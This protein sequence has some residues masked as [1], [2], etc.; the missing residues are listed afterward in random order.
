VWS[1]Y[2]GNLD[3]DNS[4]STGINN[5]GNIFIGSSNIADGAGRQLWDFKYGNLRGD[6]RH[7]L[8]LYGSYRLPWN[9]S[10]GAFA[11][12]QSGQPWET[13]NFQPYSNL[14][15]STDETIRYAEPAGSHT[16]DNHYQADLNYTQNFP[17]GERFNVQLRLDVFNVTDNQTGYSIEPR[18]HSAGFGQP[19]LFFEPRRLQLAVRFEF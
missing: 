18:A 16:S 11:I 8:K 4:A 6:R 10:A 3:Q 5:D 7:Q 12:Y 14:T 13:W 15:S 1:H 19:R 2:Y 9:A 17:I